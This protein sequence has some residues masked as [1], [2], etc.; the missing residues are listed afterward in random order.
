MPLVNCDVNLSLT[1]SS[2]CNIS[3][4]TV[5]GRFAIIDTKLHIPVITLSSQDN[6]KLLQQLK[7]GFKRKI[8]LKKYQSDPKSYA[9]SQYLNH[10]VGPSFQGVN[11]FFVLFFENENG[12]TS[13][14][15]YDLLKGEIKDHNFKIDGKT[16]LIKA[17]E[18]LLLVTEMVILLVVS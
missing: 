3:N 12:R 13:H 10:L 17:S 11:R 4:S 1:W 2:T 14:S 6:A 16:F 15:E 7:S 18:K 9:Q 5:S 8:N